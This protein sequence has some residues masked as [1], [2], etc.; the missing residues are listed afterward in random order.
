M[1]LEENGVVTSNS[2][3]IASTE[4]PAPADVGDTPT[5]VNWSDMALEMDQGDDDT[6]G[7]VEGDS[8]VIEASENAD[9]S[10][11]VPPTSTPP[12]VQ[13]PPTEPTPPVPATQVPPVQ[14]PAATQPPTPPQ[15]PPAQPQPQYAEWR[16][17]QLEALEKHYA[18][19]DESATKMLTEPETV[20]P[21]LAAQLHMEVTEH[22]MRSVF[23]AI[24]QWV[25]QVNDATSTETKAETVFYETNPDLKDPSYRSA[26]IQMGTVFR[27]L[28]PNAAPEEAVK[29]IGNMVR[30]AMGLA[31]LQPSQSGAIPTAA[32]TTPSA[33]PFTPARGGGG[34]AVPTPASNNPWAT[35]AQ[36]FLDD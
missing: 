30:S 25:K 3:P 17:K 20:I 28:N 14:P 12:A 34:G 2:D 26:I 8:E 4:S 27:Q 33:A 16:G 21:K 1:S 35:M 23:Q 22:V 18:F 6:G 13:A 11:E 36:E 7:A 32:V 10:T 29:T 19:S 5:D 15:E 9:Q 24:P 31:P